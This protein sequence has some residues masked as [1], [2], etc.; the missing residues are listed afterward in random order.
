L[1]DEIFGQEFPE[2]RNHRSRF[3]G[4]SPFMGMDPLFNPFSN[5]FGRTPVGMP[6]MFAR[7]E[8]D[9]FGM[10][11]GFPSH[12]LLPSH[13]FPT[14]EPPFRDRRDA[15]GH[16]RQE[17]YMT[18]TINGVTQSIHKR[19]D[20]DG[21]EHVTRT[22]PD[23]RKIYT[24]NGVEQL[25][26]GQLP[27]PDAGGSTG[28]LLPAR[29][30][31]RSS[32]SQLVQTAPRPETITIRSPPPPYPGRTTAYS[33]SAEHNPRDRDSGTRYE[34]HPTDNGYDVDPDGDTRMYAT[35]ENRRRNRRSWGPGRW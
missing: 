1:F 21:N 23:G 29:R 30:N 22:Y 17:S 19:I 25:V 12:P 20:S 15:S 3:H 6:G 28:R 34:R 16:F 4:P 9:L 26:H 32:T 31:S 5:P 35:D 8:Q 13:S 33:A 27:G 11:S 18:Q 24:I 2:W 14:L 10:S 7:M